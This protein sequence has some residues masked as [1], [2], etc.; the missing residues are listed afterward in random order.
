MVNLCLLVWV[1]SV[2]F[3][4]IKTASRRYVP[5]E[6]IG[7][8]PVYEKELIFKVENGVVVNHEVIENELP[9]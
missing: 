1:V 4:K 2:V 7:V 8:D 6:S 9:F 3:I 5:N